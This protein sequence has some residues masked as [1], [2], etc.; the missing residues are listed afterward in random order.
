MVSRPTIV[1]IDN[2]KTVYIDAPSGWKVVVTHLLPS[3]EAIKEK[4]SID[5]DKIFAVKELRKLLG[6]GLYEAKKMT[7]TWD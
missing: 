2:A 6:L 5:K 1:T 3:V 4:Y 7:D